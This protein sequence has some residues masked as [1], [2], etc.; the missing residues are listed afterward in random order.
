MTKITI[1]TAE[2]KSKIRGFDYCAIGQRK[3]TRSGE[4]TPLE[5]VLLTGMLL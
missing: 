2:Q 4:V 3:G 1:I 5:S